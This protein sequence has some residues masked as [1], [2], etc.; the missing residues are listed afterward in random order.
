[1]KKMA[2]LVILL[3]ETEKY[4]YWEADNKELVVPDELL[5]QWVAAVTGMEATIAKYRLLTKDKD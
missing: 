4:K 1:M 3:T 2:E 5:P